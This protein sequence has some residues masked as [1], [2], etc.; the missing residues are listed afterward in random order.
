MPRRSLDPHF[1][2][3]PPEWT[4]RK[5]QL[6]ERIVV[7]SAEKMKGIRNCLALVDGYAGPNSY[8]DAI[9]GSTVI[10]CRAAQRLAGKG[11]PVRVFAC[12]PEPDR[13]QQLVSNLAPQIESGLLTACQ[14]SHSEAV[15]EILRT[16][17]GWPAFVFLDPH[18]PK[19]LRLKDDL[20]PWLRRPMTDVL[21][22]FM[23]L[24]AARACAEAASPKGSP[25]SQATARAI[26]GD[27]WREVDS[28]ID[29]HR[30]FIQ[31]LSG[32]K[33][34]T[35]LYPLR[36]KQTLHRAYAIFGAS[37][38][39]HGFH[40]LSDAVARDWGALK[41]FDFARK[42]ATLF[43]ELDPEDEQQEE[44]DRLVQLVRPILL[45]Q[46][47]LSGQKLA[48]ALY[49]SLQSPGSIFGQFVERDFTRA[50]QSVRKRAQ[51]G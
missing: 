4:K 29:A 17:E 11:V 14:M 49:R 22:I 37:D 50:A 48:L 8:G 24:A 15:P 12:E 2:D 34:F 36:K 32:L 44:F 13:F 39:V 1:Q 43:S 20:V 16:I 45:H 51:D 40:L 3:E 35:G 26:L 25:A 41:D 10:L 5:H 21:G 23:A 42:P 47:E 7:P 33:R 6:L 27:R 18:G 38:S 9:Q 46:P 30:L 19:D 31:E 28:E